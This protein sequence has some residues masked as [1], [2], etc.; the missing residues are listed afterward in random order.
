MD[1]AMFQG[2]LVRSDRIV[3]TP[4]S[5][6]K[7]NLIYLQETGRLEA[8]EPHTS[9]REHLASYL[10]FLVEKG[11]GTVH[12]GGRQFQLTA[13]DCAFLDCSTPYSHRSSENLWALRWAHF[14]GAGMPGIYEKYIQRGGAVCFPTRYGQQYRAL[15]QEIHEIAASELYIRDMKLYEKLVCLLTLL[16][17]ESWNPSGQACGSRRARRDL[18]PVRRYLEEHYQQRISLDELAEQFYI[19]K[20]YLTRIFKEYYGVS[21]NSYLQQLRITQAKQLLRFTNLPVE[22]IAAQCGIP[23]PNYFSRAFRKVEGVSPGQF[24]SM[25]NRIDFH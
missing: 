7:A 4:S 6:A 2:N 11:E 14:Y 8:L 17:E 12:F 21:V 15:L 9:Q 3:Y 5:F 25:W 23:D 22:Q 1:T 20:Y 16:M 24:R 18:Q 13:G 19:N 10:F